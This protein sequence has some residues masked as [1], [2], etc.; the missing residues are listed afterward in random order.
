M[1]FNNVRIALKYADLAAWEA[2]SLVLKA[3]EVAIAVVPVGEGFDVM[4]KVGDGSKTFKDLEWAYSSKV[5]KD[6]L[7][8]TLA[9]Y[10]TEEEV[11]DLF[12]ERDSAWEEH[13]GAFEALSETVAGLHN[14]NDAELRQL[15]AGE[16]TRATGAEEALG[17]RIDDEATARQQGDEAANTA[18]QNAQT[19][20]DQAYELAGTKTTMAEVE[21]KDYATKTEAQGYANK[22]LEDAKKFANENDADDKF[23]I[24]F[25]SETKEIVLTGSNGTNSKI[26]AA[27]FIKDGMLEDVAYDA[28]T[29]TI[30]FTWNT[31]AGSKTDTITLTDLLDPYTAKDTDTIDLTVEGTEISAEVKDGSISEAKLT[32]ELAGKINGKEEAGVAQDLVDGLANGAVKANTEAIEAINDA[33][34][35]I[36]AQA[37]K[38]A[39]DNDT[40][41]T[42]SNGTGLKLD[43][44]VFSIDENTEW[45]FNCGGAN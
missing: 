34:T 33:E 1:N 26:S 36:L 4:F 8:T 11:N 19:K 6:E 13:I 12:A 42:Y 24:S 43:G 10:Y 30:T 45:I 32:T 35:G 41:T 15:I 25:D 27:A 17:K 9:G 21:A 2:R 14:Y 28:E 7:A 29:N 39:D 5:D 38:Y 18:A 23:E 40:D 31:D 37:K 16:V 3:G 22:A 44:T 20:A